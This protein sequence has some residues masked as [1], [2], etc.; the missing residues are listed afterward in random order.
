MNA[1]NAKLDIDGTKFKQNVCLHAHM[2]NIGITLLRVA[3]LALSQIVRFV[4]LRILAQHVFLDIN[5][6]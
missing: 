3:H 1:L 2:V 5:L 4:L 6:I